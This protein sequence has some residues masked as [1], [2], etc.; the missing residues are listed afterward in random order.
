MIAEKDAR[1]DEKTGTADGGSPGPANAAASVD[2]GELA[3][4]AAIAEE[5]W[6]PHGKFKPLHQLNPTRLGYVRQQI[7]AHFGRD[8]RAGAALDGLTVLDIGCGG[9]LLCEPIARQGATTTG[10]DPSEKTIRIA[11][12]HA[13]SSGADV[14]YET[15]TVEALVEAERRF[16]VVIAMEVVEHVN[17][18]ETFVSGCA[19]LVAPGGLFIASTI[20]R[21]LKAYA[22][23]I[24]GAERVMRWLPV[25]THHYDKLVRPKELESAV[26]TGGLT[27]IDTTGMVYNPLTGAWRLSE[28]DLDVNY[29]LTATRPAP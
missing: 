7:C 9:G 25:G 23:A 22:L 15:T 13:R 27:P 11:R 18:V 28:G 2:A 12:A 21:T 6:D 16:D 29:L 4:F 1:S 20:N 3:R 14:T 26:T 24:V 10:I 8:V 5:W 19:E 17:H